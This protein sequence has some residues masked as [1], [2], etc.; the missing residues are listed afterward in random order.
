MK[1]T[2]RLRVWLRAEAQRRNLSYAELA[3]RG[4]TNYQN[5]QRLLQG[6]TEEISDEMERAVC[7]AFNLTLVELLRIANHDHGLSAEYDTECETARAVWRWIAYDAN[8]IAAIL[9]A[10]GVSG[11]HTTFHS[12]RHTFRTRLSEAGAPQE[13]AMALGGWTQAA[14]AGLYSHDWGALDKAVRA[15]K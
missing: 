5:W 6:K 3:R 15:M 10:A 14:T 2:D 7:S 11:G 1:V 4:A 13:I 9:R 8:R 12:W